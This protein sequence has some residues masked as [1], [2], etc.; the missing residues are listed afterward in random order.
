[1][2]YPVWS[3]YPKNVMAPG[4]TARLIDVVEAAEPS[5]STPAGNRLTSDQVLAVLA[6]DL[7]PL[8]WECERNKTS[9]GKIRRP[10][11]FGENGVPSVRY[12]V[13]AVHDTER[14]VME[15]EAGRG[16]RGNA[17]YRDLI[18]TSLILD[19]DFFVLLLP[20]LYR[21]GAKGTEVPAYR[22]CRDL[23]DAV[24][25]SRRLQLPFTGLLLV[26]Y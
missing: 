6:D 14:I 25:A 3:Y 24:Y 18:R 16:A 4:W 8:G 10:V 17:A 2:S 11:L 15:V 22:D 20:V 1:V 19:A 21:Y 7:E 5:I 26:G 12:E 23:L 13:D 9:A